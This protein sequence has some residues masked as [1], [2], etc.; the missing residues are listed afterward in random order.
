MD[1][2]GITELLQQVARGETSVEDAVLKLTD[3]VTEDNEHD[4][5]A[6]AMIRWVL[7]EEN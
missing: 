3:L 2:Q 6:R 7:E 4:G 5:A 1:K